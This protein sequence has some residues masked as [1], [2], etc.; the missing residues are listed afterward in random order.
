MKYMNAMISKME[1]IIY[2]FNKIRKL[3]FKF[4]NQ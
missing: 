3:C 1:Q 4:K 2:C